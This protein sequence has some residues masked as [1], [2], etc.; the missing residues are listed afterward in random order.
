LPYRYWEQNGITGFYNES[1]ITCPVC[2]FAQEAVM[3]ERSCA[4][5]YRCSQGG[6][7]LWPAEGDC[8]VYCTYG[9]VPCQAIQVER[10]RPEA[11]G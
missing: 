1:T 6:T 11:T 3:P 2:G 7:D 9:S 5:T 8:C 10:A 4:I